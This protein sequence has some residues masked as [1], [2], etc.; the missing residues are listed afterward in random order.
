MNEIKPEVN[1]RHFI[2]SIS[3]VCQEFAFTFMHPF[4]DPIYLNYERIQREVL[5]LFKA[6]KMTNPGITIG[7]Y[8]EITANEI[9]YFF[10]KSPIVNPLKIL[11]K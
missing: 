3:L 6:Q 9:T 1:L 5:E 4:S 7:F 10:K 2:C 11:K 8:Q